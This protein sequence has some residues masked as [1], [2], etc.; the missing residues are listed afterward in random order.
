MVT[1]PLSRRVAGQGRRPSC[2]GELHGK[3]L[4]VT[5]EDWHHLCWCGFNI[6]LYFSYVARARIGN[7]FIG[8]IGRIRAAVNY[9]ESRL[10]P[11][12]GFA[13][14]RTT[15]K[16]PSLKSTR[17]DN[18]VLFCHQYFSRIIVISDSLIMIVSLNNTLKSIKK[19]HCDFIWSTLYDRPYLRLTIDDVNE[20][21]TNFRT[22]IEIIKN[23][24]RAFHWKY[25]HRRFQG[26]CRS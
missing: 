22:C 7:K 25:G 8:G 14:R 5:K 6:A 2:P 9:N 26:G 16:Q 13:G 20:L 10:M 12:A 23:N 24:S 4:I 1:N 3:K 11:A 18:I 15:S 19:Y 21:I 17:N